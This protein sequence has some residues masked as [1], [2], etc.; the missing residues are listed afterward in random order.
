MSSKKSSGP[1]STSKKGDTN[2]PTLCKES[3]GPEIVRHQQTVSTIGKF[4]QKN[5]GAASKKD[6][7][8]NRRIGKDEDLVKKKK[9]KGEIKLDKLRNKKMLNDSGKAIVGNLYIN[10]SVAFQ[11]LDFKLFVAGE[12]EII[13]SRKIKIDERNIRLSF[14]KKKIVCF[15]NIYQCKALLDYAAFLRQMETGVKTLE[16]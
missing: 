1:L 11:D 2:V 16:R 8:P 10:K 15:S 3:S 14:L 13:S 5:I 9:K 6:E 7:K 4:G 12:L